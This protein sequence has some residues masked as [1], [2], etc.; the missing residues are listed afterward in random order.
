MEATTA[1]GVEIASNPMMVGRVQVDRKDLIR[2]VQTALRSVNEKSPM[3]V[4]SLV[5]LTWEQFHMEAAGTDLTTSV[6]VQMRAT[7]FIPCGICID[8]QKLVSAVKYMHDPRVELIMPDETTLIITSAGERDESVRLHGIEVGDFPALPK[9]HTHIHTMAGADVARM[10]G[11]CHPATLRSATLPILAGVFVCWNEHGLTMAATDRH[12]LHMEKLLASTQ[13]AFSC[14]IPE[15]G[16][17][18]LVAVIDPNQPIEIWTSEQGTQLVFIQNTMQYTSNT[19]D[20]QYPDVMR[21][22]PLSYAC[23]AVVDVAELRRA[24]YLVRELAKGNDGAI[25]M[26]FNPDSITIDAQSSG[27]GSGI[28]TINATVN[29]SVVTQLGLPLLLDGLAVLHTE[30][31]AI[32]LTQGNHPIVLREVEGNEHAV[33]VIVPRG[34][35]SS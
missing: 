3:P 27:V 25:R 15:P 35:K 1:P 20:G 5:R 28:T 19:I 8:G 14:V 33:V 29:G 26:A 32:E 7:T 11:R 31:V 22:V 23:R 13:K 21:F 18:E 12:R 17:P 4:L 10:L 30:H 6:A 9:P 16:I 2:I 24:L 34:Q